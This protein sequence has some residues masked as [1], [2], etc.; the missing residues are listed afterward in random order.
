[1]NKYLKKEKTEKRKKKELFDV[2]ELDLYNQ[3]MKE[4]QKELDSK[5]FV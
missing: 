1:M 2:F 3:Y 4:I 5:Y